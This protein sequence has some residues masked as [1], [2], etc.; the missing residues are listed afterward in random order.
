MFIRVLSCVVG[1]M[2][3]TQRVSSLSVMNAASLPFTVGDSVETLAG[4]VQVKLIVF[5]LS[6][7]SL[8]KFSLVL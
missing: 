8:R 7:A 1:L 6:V 4:E 2:H 5:H 3:K